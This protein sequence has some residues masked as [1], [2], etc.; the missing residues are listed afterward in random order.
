ML[1]LISFGGGMADAADAQKPLIQKGAGNR[2]TLDFREIELTDLIQTISELT[3]KNFLYDDTVKGKATIVSPEGMTVDEAYQ[4][5]QTVL[6]IKGFTIVPS[7]KV[8]KIVA[9]K[10]AKES[11]LPIVTG[12]QKAT[13]QYITR[14]L[15]LEN[16]D[17]ATIADAVLT[18]LIPATGNVVVYSPTNTLLITDSAS[19]IERLVKI[20]KELDQP[21][22]ARMLEVIPLQYA[23]ADD[24]AKICTEVL[25]QG[26]ATAVRRG[27]AEAAAATS[28]DFS[29]A[30]VLPYARANA[31]VV[32][33]SAEQLATIRELIAKMDRDT[34]GGYSSVNVY[35]LENADAETLA[36]TMNEIL[37]GIRAEIRGGGQGKGPVSS[38]PV[39]I[40][41]D[42]PTN[43]LVINAKPEDYASLRRIIEKLDVKRKQVYVEALIMEL[44]M[45]A[46]QK[47][48]V[49]LQGGASYK[50]DG[51]ILGSSNLNKGSVGFGDLS[52]GTSGVPSLLTKAVDGLLAGGFFNPI[53]ITGPDGKEITVPTLSVLIDLSKSDGDVNILSAP[54]L[55]TSD[56]EEAEIIVGSNVPII[57]SRLTGAVGNVTN[58]SNGLA[59][60]V[61][62]ERKD[63]ALILRFTPQ[64]TEGD[65][66]RLNVYQEM[67]DIVPAS[68][69]LAASVGNPNDV[70]PTFTKR[71]L[72]NTVLAE[73]G[74]TV[75]LGGLIGTNVSE[76][77]SKTPLLGDIPLLGWLFKR[78]ETQETK[79]NLLIFINP[80]VIRGPEDLAR[81]TGRNRVM[82]D[83]LMNERTRS[84][85]PENY[86]APGT[87]REDD[88][89]KPAAQDSPPQPTP[90]TPSSKVAPPA[91][92]A[93]APP[94]DAA[95][96]PD[97]PQPPQPP[98]ITTLP[99]AP[100]KTAAATGASNVLPRVLDEKWATP[101]P[102]RQP[103]L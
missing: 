35:P 61:S 16:L 74:K 88:Q 76:K 65:L 42:K 82:A 47:L 59:T 93:S 19:N 57:T 9:V 69:G 63:V 24:L 32:M 83:G 94:P 10:G 14:L 90:A 30:K 85:L 73:N 5:F 102:Q 55:L 22:S 23:G 48:G 8:N 52:T 80:T 53:T 78:K 89:S 3:G 60:S 12:E 87:T 66:V 45:D 21:G 38:G 99:P 15:R 4:L 100:E 91:P 33:A 39:T 46:T 34:G 50:D 18:P 101:R 20:I 6:N 43:A 79:T 7:G 64:V 84:S 37:T 86:F 51:L 58:T 103:T 41:A 95:G 96:Q 70:G 75:V 67:T 29:P 40:T 54:R 72:R 56:N 68:A 81:V 92:A 2:V 28:A 49:S 97:A 1:V 25:N 11:N 31:L 44:S 77:I 26:G 17:A 62:V 98:P 36:K 27:R 13:E 71:V